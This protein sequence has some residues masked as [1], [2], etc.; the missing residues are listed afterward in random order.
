MIRSNKESKVEP[1][2]Y[3]GVIVK[4]NPITLENKR[5]GYRIWLNVDG[6]IK[7]IEFESM[8]EKDLAAYIARLMQMGHRRLNSVVTQ[9][10]LIPRL[11][12]DKKVHQ[13]EPIFTFLRDK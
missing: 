3:R 11:S 10:D 4:H 6:E 12:K 13:P 9:V 2:V 1:L 5:M 7:D 8:Y